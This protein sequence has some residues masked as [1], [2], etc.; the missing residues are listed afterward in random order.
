[1]VEFKD[2]GA[3]GKFVSIVPQEEATN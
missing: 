1:V 2:R 3:M